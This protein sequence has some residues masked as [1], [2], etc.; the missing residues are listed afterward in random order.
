MRIALFTILAVGLAAVAAAVARTS[1]DD[2]PAATEAEKMQTKAKAFLDQ[3]QADLA[4]LDKEAKLADW[5]AATSGKAE[6]YEKW[7]NRA[8]APAIPQR[9]GG[10]SRDLRALA[11]QGVL[12]PDDHPGTCRR[13]AGLRGE[14]VARRSAQG[15]VTQATEIES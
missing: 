7:P 2:D 1:D 13:Q 11:R 14:P 5:A 10:L 6:D 4:R 3:Y 12:R 9:P 15:M 8:G